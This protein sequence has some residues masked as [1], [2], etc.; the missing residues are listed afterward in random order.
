MPSPSQSDVHV[1]KIAPSLFAVI[2]IVDWNRVCV[3]QIDGK[4]LR[5][6]P[7]CH[8]W[9]H[10]IRDGGNHVA[11]TTITNEEVSTYVRLD[12]LVCGGKGCRPINGLYLDCRRCNWD[13]KQIHNCPI[14]GKKVGASNYHR[15]KSNQKPGRQVLVH[16]DGKFMLKS[17]CSDRCA[18]A[19]ELRLKMFSASANQCH[20]ASSFVY[21]I[22]NETESRVK[23]GFSKDPFHRLARLQTGNHGTLHLI[24]A[25]PGTVETEAAWHRRFSRVRIQG[26][27][28]QL[29]A[30]LRSAIEAAIAL[31]AD[32]HSRN[33]DKH[34]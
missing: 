11:G 9:K 25:I 18:E 1:V 32:E 21:F 8:E 27:W 4:E 2:D 7:S 14:C 28:F 6:Q 16:F 10:H 26:E 30:H 34:I 24:A 15:M 22:A 5:I 33:L 3:A 17:A 29:T 23:I 20:D 12:W 13:V 19:A 31:T